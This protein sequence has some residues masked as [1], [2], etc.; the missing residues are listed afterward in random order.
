MDK[1]EIIH[2]LNLLQMRMGNQKILGEGLKHA[3]PKYVYTR[4]TVG[5]WIALIDSGQIGKDLIT[6]MY[7]CNELWQKAKK[8]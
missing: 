1:M 7:L 3:L 8:S 6:V 4:E 5:K 2:R